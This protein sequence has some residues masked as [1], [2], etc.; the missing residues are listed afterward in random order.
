MARNPRRL[1]FEPLQPEGRWISAY[2]ACERFL[3]VIRDSYPAVLDSLGAYFDAFPTSPSSDDSKKKALEWLRRWVLRHR[4][5]SDL[6]LRAA[7]TTVSGWRQD[8]TALE[9]RR[10][11]FPDV[12]YAR[13]PLTAKVPEHPESVD[14]ATWMQIYDQRIAH[15]KDT[16]WSV[17]PSKD[18]EHF[19]WLADLVVGGQ[20]FSDI[21]RAAHVNVTAVH[22]DLTTLAELIGL[23]LPEPAKGGRPRKRST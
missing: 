23:T 6:V 10:W 13:P 14:R 1:G 17:A 20:T 3:T 7:A 12:Q 16:G 18:P 5:S 4:L 2:V 8:P 15:L 9:E 21:A 19:R 22:Q 11:I